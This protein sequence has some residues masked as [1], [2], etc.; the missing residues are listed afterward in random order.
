M[1]EDVRLA[2]GSGVTIDF[3]GRWGGIIPTEREIEREVQRLEVAAA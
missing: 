1:I 2:V 3:L